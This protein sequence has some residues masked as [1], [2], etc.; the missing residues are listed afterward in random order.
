MSAIQAYQGFAGNYGGARRRATC[1]KAND[2][3]DM[4][5]HPTRGTPT[6]RGACHGKGGAR[7][8]YVRRFDGPD[9]AKDF[10]F[11]IRHESASDG[12]VVPEKPGPAQAALWMEPLGATPRGAGDRR[13]G[14]SK[15]AAKADWRPRKPRTGL[16]AMRQADAP[17]S[18]RGAGVGVCL[19][20]RLSGRPAVMDTR[21]PCSACRTRK[22]IFYFAAIK[23]RLPARSWIDGL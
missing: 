5:K 20:T 9:G 1:K 4:T 8:G 2:F 11:L 18:E 15:A 19:S 22:N 13:R 16:T 3:K 21:M 17:T 14:T 23:T 6:A 12:P 10:P 7:L